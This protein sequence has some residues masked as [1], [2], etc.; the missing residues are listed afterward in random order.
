MET[1]V[2]W[3]DVPTPLPTGP[4]RVAVTD[5]GVIGAT[6]GPGDMLHAT[7]GDAV[8]E[9]AP[10]GDE[11]AER[12]AARLGEYFAGRR[13]GFELP[14]DWR[15][16]DGV[17]R[18]VLQTLERTVAYGHTV[19]YGQLAARSGAFEEE[20]EQHLAARAVGQIMGSNPLFLLVPCHRVVA[21]DG[22]GGFGGGEAGMSVKRWLLTLEGYLPPTL[23]WD[24]PDVPA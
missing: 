17:Q 11:R 19:T 18:Q 2:H 24:G 6:F 12:V 4:V 10:E 13:R 23:D 22:L 1:R 20:V 14:L 15:W 16:T 8:G 21:A 3:V 5:Q 7:R 9:P